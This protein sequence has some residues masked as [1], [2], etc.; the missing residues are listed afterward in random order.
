MLVSCGRIS[1][2]SVIAA[3]IITCREVLVSGL[4]EFLSEL[5]VVVHV[6]QLAKWKTAIQMAALSF[7]IIGDAGPPQLNAVLW[8]N[9]ALWAAALL[10]VVTGIDY[11]VTG[12]GHIVAAD[13]T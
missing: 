4:R 6:S 5:Q 9:Y 3:V 12:M 8:G 2:Y 1:G 10:T 11:L 13:R 7:L